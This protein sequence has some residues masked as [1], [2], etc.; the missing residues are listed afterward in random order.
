M[1][2]L[3]GMADIHPGSSF[4]YLHAMSKLS[5]MISLM[6]VTGLPQETEDTNKQDQAV[7]VPW[8]P[9]REQSWLHE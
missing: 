8:A 6:P 9:L 1:W 2:F 3:C 5:S 7:L 4:P